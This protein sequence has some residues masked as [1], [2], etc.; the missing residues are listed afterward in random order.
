[1]GK[2]PPQSHAALV[3][4]EIEAVGDLFK[5][6]KDSRVRVIRLGRAA[7]ITYTQIGERLGISDAAVIGILKRAGDDS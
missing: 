1:M 6:T 2:V 7:G 3:L 5:S 4:E